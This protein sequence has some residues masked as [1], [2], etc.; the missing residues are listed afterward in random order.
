[1]RKGFEGRTTPD[2]FRTRLGLPPNGPFP[3]TVHQLLIDPGLP[4]TEYFRENFLDRRGYRCDCHNDK[5]PGFL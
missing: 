1:M 2:D 4:A 3:V 5:L